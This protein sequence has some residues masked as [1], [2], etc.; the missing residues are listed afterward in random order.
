MSR[1]RYRYS[2]M[3]KAELVERLL[4]VEKEYAEQEALWLQVNEELVT[5]RLRAE[6]EEARARSELAARNKGQKE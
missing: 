5:W 4:I 3:S 6:R 2:K 1:A